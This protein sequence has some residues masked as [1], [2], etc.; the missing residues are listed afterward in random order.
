MTE[1]RESA[2][3]A[4][5]VRLV[6]TA[7]ALT[8]KLAPTVAGIPDRLVVWPGGT[9]DFVEVKADGGTV[10]PIQKAR[11]TELRDRNANVFVA[12]GNAG[13]EEYLAA[14]LDT[15]DLALR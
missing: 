15:L 4:R 8:Y 2:T 14:R 7:G 6:R 1:R 10:A 12:H 3:E 5:L 13:V 9:I 11:I